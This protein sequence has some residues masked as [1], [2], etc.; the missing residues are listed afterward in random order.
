MP[1]KLFETLAKQGDAYLYDG[2]KSVSVQ[3]QSATRTD[4]RPYRYA[5][6][7]RFINDAGDESAKWHFVADS[8]EALRLSLSYNHVSDDDYRWM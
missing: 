3:D 6:T 2:Q 4:E 8:D 7:V 1:T 5:V